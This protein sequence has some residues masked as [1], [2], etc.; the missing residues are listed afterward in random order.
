MMHQKENWY[1]WLAQLFKEFIAEKLNETSYKIVDLYEC[2]NTGLKKAVIK[3]SERH[4]QHKNIS[5]IVADDSL[6][7]GLDSKTVRTLTYIATLEKLTPDF[8]I[9]IQKVDGKS[10]EYILE[11]KSR[12]GKIIHKNPVELCREKAMIAS[13]SPEDA[14]RVGYLSGVSET[15]KEFRLVNNR[16]M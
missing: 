1:S 7:D 10:D 2:E 15:I 11:L 13:L 9:V 3:L 16:N 12:D 14:N 4:I 8:S 6:I 5:E